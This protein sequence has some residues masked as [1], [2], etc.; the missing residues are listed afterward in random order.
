MRMMS[1]S[2]TKSG[3]LTES[4]R[5][6][7]ASE[8]VAMSETGDCWSAGV[9]NGSNYALYYF[10]GCTS[11]GVPARQWLNRE[12]GGLDVDTHGN[13]VSIDQGAASLY[14]YRGC[15]PLCR[16]VGGPFALHDDAQYGHLNLPRQP[17]CGSEL[18]CD[19]HLSVRPARAHIRIQHYKR[20]RRRKRSSLQPRPLTT[21]IAL[22]H[23]TPS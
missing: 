9:D 4:G 20:R 6:L 5:G 16:K 3:N 18:Q 19:R 11:P 10:K 14:V 7:A 13:L 17:I 12:W 8:S 2:L 23:R 21:A 22:I 15:D 1:P